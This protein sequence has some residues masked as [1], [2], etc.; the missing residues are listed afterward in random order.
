SKYLYGF[1]VEKIVLIGCFAH[2]FW[3]TERFGEILNIPSKIIM[4]MCRLLE[5]KYNNLL[6]WDELDITK[7]V[8]RDSSSVMLI[9]DTDDKE[10][11]YSNAT[12]FL[13]ACEEKLVFVS[14]NKL[15]HRRILRDA[16]IIAEVC[17]FIASDNSLS[18]SQKSF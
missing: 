18:I 13:E 15:G 6:K 11:P 14:S 12:K 17:N 9:H 7:L 4:R 2:G 10:I 16:R 1:D 8:E 5:E 3:V